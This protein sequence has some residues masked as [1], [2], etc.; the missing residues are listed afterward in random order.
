MQGSYRTL[1]QGNRGSMRQCSENSGS[2]RPWP[3]GRSTPRRQ[4]KRESW[5][6]VDLN[7]EQALSVSLSYRARKIGASLPRLTSIF[8]SDNLSFVVDGVSD[9]AVGVAKGDTN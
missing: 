9:G 8:V 2:G 6:F 5:G 4:R 1:S 3:A 7:T